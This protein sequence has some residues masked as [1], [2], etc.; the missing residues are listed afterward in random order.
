MVGVDWPEG[1]EKAMRDLADEWHAAGQR[2]GPRLD[3]ADHAA[4]SAVAAFGGPQGREA[5]AL[6]TL[7]RKLG[8]GPESAMVVVHEFLSELGNLVDAGA[9]EIE[10]VKLEF[11]IELA[12]LL[13][14]LLTLIATAV[15]T[16]GGSLAA[17]GPIMLATRFAIQQILRRATKD[18]LE[19]AVKKSLR[20]K[21]KSRMAAFSLHTFR[22][23]LEEGF[24]ELGTS[25]GIQ[26]YQISEG[27]RAGFAPSDLAT[28]FGL[29]TL[30]GAVANVTGVGGVK[31]TTMS[32]PLRRESAA[33]RDRRDAGRNLDRHSHRP[34]RHLDLTEHGRI[35]RRRRLGDGRR[36]ARHRCPPHQRLHPLEQET[37]DSTRRFRCDRYDGYGLCW[38]PHP[39]LAGRA[40]GAATAVPD[41]GLSAVAPVPCDAPTAGVAVPNAGLL[42]A[43]PVSGTALPG[44]SSAMTAPD[45]V[46]S[47]TP[48]V[49]SPAESAQSPNPSV[50]PD[51]SPRISAPPEPSHGRSSWESPSAAHSPQSVAG[52]SGRRQAAAIRAACSRCGRSI[53]ERRRSRRDIDSCGCLATRREPGRHHPAGAAAVPSST[54][55][56]VVS[57]SAAAAPMV[58]PS[59]PAPAHAVPP[60]HHAPPATPAAPPPPAPP[61][62][63]LPLGGGPSSA[64]FRAPES[65]T[66]SDGPIVLHT[67]LLADVA[68]KTVAPP[69]VPV[70]PEP[71]V[72]DDPG[73]RAFYAETV[74]GE[75]QGAL[76]RRLL[77]V[78]DQLMADW[79]ERRSVLRE[80][81]IA[82]LTQQDLEVV[83]DELWQIA[84]SDS[85]RP[86]V[87]LANGGLIDWSTV[88]LATGSDHPPAAERTR[89]YDEPGGYR[90]PL[91]LHQQDVELAVA[92][93]ENGRPQRFGDLNGEWLR[94]INDGGPSADLSRGINCTDV[95]L[96]VLDTWL[97]GRP[98][99]AAPRT[100]D[101]FTLDDSLRPLG[102][103]PG[104]VHRIEAATGGHFERLRCDRPGFAR[105][106]EVLSRHGHGSC[107]VLVQQ[108]PNGDS[109]A[110]TV[111]NQNGKIFYV[112]AQRPEAPIIGGAPLGADR[113]QVLILDPSATPIELGTGSATWDVDPEGHPRAHSKP[114]TDSIG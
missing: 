38:P 109:H 19:R 107:A 12:L 92:R 53:A 86:R 51:H 5:E 106:E 69:P 13:I 55:V 47:A 21:A 63:P 104:G 16:F 100:I 61:I 17:A 23:A 87:R 67:W 6:L 49:P 110:T 88:S 65:G 31:A 85:L 62:V 74:R 101:R 2:L 10:G 80:N 78:V 113:M 89:R 96:S 39:F 98:R 102:G 77:Q 14:E 45:A 71:I 91:A 26:A 93:D 111:H 22:E 70:V 114:I 7:W 4:L 41:A 18:L 84:N 105:L 29:G 94:R 58:S 66:V 81:A 56:P 9:N 35:L 60:A 72:S 40:T 42:A 48:P 90:R 33:R 68:T 43:P 59:V 50:S 30:G 3:E 24:Q 76:T 25:S 32:W 11:Y 20:D 54:A 95:V 75:I 73:E 44:L 64:A 46:L 27:N 28:A 82:A 1:D 57:P 103:E 8:G 34:G 108:W 52:W 37:L 36:P 112:D 99:V 97:H 15:L 79:P 83:A